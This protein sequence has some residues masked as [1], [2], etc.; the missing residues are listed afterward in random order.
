MS[1]EQEFVET[2]SGCSLCGLPTPDPA[3]S[4]DG[5][6]GG[7]CCRGCLEV[8]R[9]LGETTEK[10]LEREEEEDLGVGGEGDVGF[11]GVD[12]MHCSSCELFIEGRVE[13]L[14]GVYG[15]DASYASD[16]LR[17]SYD[18]DI[19]GEAEVRDAVGGLGYRARDPE[20]GRGDSLLE[21]VNFL[22][23]VVGGQVGM[24]VMI[25]YALFLY[26]GYLGL[27]PPVANP[28][29]EAFTVFYLWSFSSFVL[30]VSGYPL[31][32]SAWVSLRAGTPNMDLL[33]ALAAV[34]AYVYSSLSVLLGGR[35]IYFDV[36][37]VIVLV[38][39]FG[40]YYENRVKRRASGLLEELVADRVDEARVQSGGG[41]EVVPVEELSEGDRVVVRPGERVPLDGV[42]VEGGAAVDESL[43][44]GESVPE[45]KEPGERVVG[46]SVVT[47]QQL[48]VEVPGDQ[49]STYDRLVGYFW[50]VQTS[51]SGAQRAADRLAAVFVPLVLLAAAGTFVLHVLL[52]GGVGGSLLTALAVLVVSC[53]C[54]LGL[55]TPLAV[56]GGLREGLDNG[57]VVT[58]SGVFESGGDYDVV[59]FDK[60]G[61]LTTGEM[62]VLD[63]VG[64]L[65]GGLW[66]AAA[67]ERMSNHPVAEA[68]TGYASSLA[69]VE[70]F[71]QYSRGVGGVVEGERVLVGAPTLFDD[72]GWSV[73]ED[74]RRRAEKAYNEGGVPVVVG[75]G[76]VGR[77]VLVVGDEA[78]DGW[79]EAVRSV[80]RGREVVVIS[81]DDR[82]AAKMYEWADCVDRVFAGVPPE[83]K[84]EVVERLRAEGRV[85]MVGDGSN[86][87]PALAAADLGVAMGGGTAVACN[88]ADV[89]V[90]DDDL[91]TLN[92]VLG[93]AGGVRGR[94]RQNLGWAFVYN[95]VAV[96]V[97]VA[98]LINPLVAAA[99]MSVSSLLVVVNSVRGYLG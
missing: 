46:G 12:G 23:L 6:G 9:T 98:G 1:V 30:F 81:G 36:A 25:W 38:V 78:R 35:H 84:A 89:V 15:A 70:D 34:N 37:V 26:P 49:V 59:A 44:T 97:A 91:S 82:R 53:P 41:E 90:L 28:L 65:E 83:A 43:V 14:D 27:E 45:T 17:Y 3:V 60:T 67:V 47:D 77:C 93:L 95:G 68:V 69:E 8:A 52:G 16:L 92:D 62:Q 87:A 58:G 86:D 31:L 56:A 76:G 42:V 10:E 80:G 61:T 74:V 85:V 32:R 96:P 21:Y 88:A 11:L 13:G 94:I 79:R 20:E 72:E 75:W 33:V 2:G 29:G 66:R 7:Y 40:N 55:A 64:D 48:V 71:E 99:A 63:V 22:R 39:G 4:A 24:M 73:R 5:V 19:V 18:P 50:G 51:R 54:A 57:F